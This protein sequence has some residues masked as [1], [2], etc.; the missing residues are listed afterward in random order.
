[1]S[2]YIRNTRECLVNHF[3]PEIL[4]AIQNYFQEHEVGNLQADIILCCETISRK[5]SVGKTVSWLNDKPDTT[6]Y[7]GLLLTSQWL[8]WVHHGD[9][10]GTR[11]NAANLNEIQ[12]EYYI[13]LL[14][15]DAG[16][17]IVG[18]IGDTNRRVHGY[19]GMGTELAA[20]KF[21]EEV[22]QA[23]IRVNPPAKRGLFKWF[24]S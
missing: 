10:S 21:C 8:I 5:K 17:K 18:F 16:L 19:I 1:M 3:H 6:I 13:S 24:S 23:I 4:Q 7:T 9:Q 2:E 20:Q 22:K 14:L 15:Q 11:V 12:V